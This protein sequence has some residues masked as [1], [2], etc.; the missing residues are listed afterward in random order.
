MYRAK[1]VCICADSKGTP[2]STLVFICKID[3]VLMDDGKIMT[4][5]ISIVCAPIFV[6]IRSKPPQPFKAVAAECYRSRSGLNPE[7]N[8][9]LVHSAPL[10]MS[11]PSPETM[12][13]PD[14]AMAVMAAMIKINNIAAQFDT[15][16]L[17]RVMSIPFQVMAGWPVCLN[18]QTSR[19]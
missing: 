13:Q 15:K 11:S 4:D 6:P 12:L 7:S 10:K 5:S 14:N 1:T 8:A 9:C 19:E 3:W 17:S 18:R 16:C 2:P